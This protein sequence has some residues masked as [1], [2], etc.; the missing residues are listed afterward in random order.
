MSMTYN[1]DM[2]KS[3]HYTLEHVQIHAEDGIQLPGLWYTPTHKDT[4]TAF[5]YLH[6]CGNASIFYKVQKMHTFAEILAEQGIHFF[7]FN[8]RGATYIRKLTKI[9]DG[10]EQDVKIGTALEKI[11]ESVFDISAAVAEAQARGMEKIVLIGESTGANKIVVYNH[12]QPNNPVNGY[13]LV[14]GGDDIGLWAQ[15]FGFE[16]WREVLEEAQQKVAQEEGTHLLSID[17]AESL[18][19][20]QALVDVMDPDGDYNTFPFTEYFRKEQWS[21]KPLFHMWRAVTKPTLVLYG[22]EDTFCYEKPNKVVEILAKH[23]AGG[24]KNS[25]RVIQGADHSFHGQAEKEI[26]SIFEWWHSTT[27]VK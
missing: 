1:R 12:Y 21:T 15:S 20:Y 18:L 17:A 2:P 24:A 4:K 25:Y 9:V 11:S 6:G 5:I 13:A 8:N 14:G 19:T 3:Q 16:H 22:S 23:Q 26:R 27:T 10:E 7:P